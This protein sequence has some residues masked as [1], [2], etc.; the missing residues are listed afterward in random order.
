L[1]SNALTLVASLGLLGG[2]A[3]QQ[4]QAMLQIYQDDSS[5]YLLYDYRLNT[6]KA[7]VKIHYLTESEL[8]K[9]YEDRQALWLWEQQFKSGFVG[10][11][12]TKN[13]ICNIHILEPE[14]TGKVNHKF[15]YIVGHEVMHCFINEFHVF[16]MDSWVSDDCPGNHKICS[17]KTQK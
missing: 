3:T 5:P 11:T 6:E 10:F 12:E 8:K 16:D 7:V 1:V 9:I 17:F 13:G 4:S 14:H 2:C 15:K